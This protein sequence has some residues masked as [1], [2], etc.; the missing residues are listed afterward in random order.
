MT[1]VLDEADE[2]ISMGFKDDMETILG[3]V[4]DEQSHT[5]LFSAT[6]SPE[7]SKVADDYL[8]GPERGPDQPH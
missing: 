8:Y 3:S 6:M 5:W 4:P 7:V 1:V 2:M